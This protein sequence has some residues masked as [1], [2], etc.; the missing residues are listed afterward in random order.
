[1]RGLL[2]QRWLATA[3]DG[4]VLW[5]KCVQHSPHPRECVPEAAPA[6]A[7][8][9]EAYGPG[10]IFRPETT[11]LKVRFRAAICSSVASGH[12]KPFL[13]KPGVGVLYPSSR[14][15]NAPFRSCSSWAKGSSVNCSCKR[16]CSDSALA[17]L[18]SPVTVANCSCIRSRRTSRATARHSSA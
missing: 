4:V 15:C 1:M 8:P 16:K 9:A 14:A 3:N 12:V 5:G 10:Q 18:R 6:E 17:A 11:L 2:E 7:A 13:H